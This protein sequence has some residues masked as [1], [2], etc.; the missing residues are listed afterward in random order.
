MENLWLFVHFPANAVA[1]ILPNHRVTLLFRI[2]LNGVTNITES[3]AGFDGLD[4]L[5]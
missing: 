2:T 3:G 5:P 4:A 1:A